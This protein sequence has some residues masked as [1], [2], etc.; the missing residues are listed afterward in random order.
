[1]ASYSSNQI[2]VYAGVTFFSQ[3]YSG[4]VRGVSRIFVHPNYNSSTSNADIAVLELSAPLNF[5]ADA[6]P[7][8]FDGGTGIEFPGN[9]AFISG[10]GTLSQGGTAPNQLQSAAV[11]LGDINSLQ[12]NQYSFPLNNGMIPA[13][14]TI[15]TCNGDSGGPLWVNS[16]GQSFVVGV[17]SFKPNSGCGSSNPAIFTRVSSYC[18]WVLQQV[19]NA[20]N[21]VGSGSIC[22]NESYFVNNQP[23]NTSLTWSSSNP[24]ALFI[25][26]SG[27]A[28]RQNNFNG[29][30]TITATVANACGSGN[31]SRFVTVG[32]PQ[33]GYITVNGQP[34]SNATVCVNNFASLEALP[35]DANSSYSW[36]LSNPGNAYLT[37]YYNASTAFNAY[38][39]DCYGL[40]LQVSNSCGTTQAA[41]SICAQNCFA[42][43]TVYPNPAKDHIAVE[44]ENIDNADAL[45]D[46]ITLLSE[47]STKPVKTVNVQDA[48]S[49]KAFKNGNQIELDVRDLPRGIYYLHI[50]NSRRKDNQ[51]DAIRMVLE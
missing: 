12:Q 31:I 21:I 48:F 6:Q 42:R 43:Y 2:E 49:Q 17:T 46:D 29:Q 41:L 47:K 14:G 36:S 11:G 13:G 50:N 40:T 45:P 32:P 25:N 39:A 9:L 34:T 7:I 35:F 24:S 23:L 10:W 3:R 30:V 16:N 26:N 1:M 22:N 20:A 15:S 37:N 51:V 19:S 33:V 44:F 38:T 8:R 27:V 28:T 18:Q 5:N 4:Q